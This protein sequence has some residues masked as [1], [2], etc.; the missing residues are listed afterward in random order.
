MRCIAASFISVY[1]LSNLREWTEVKSVCRSSL[2]AFIYRVCNNKN[3]LFI[4]VYSTFMWLQQNRLNLNMTKRLCVAQDW[5]SVSVFQDGIEGR[6][7]NSA[8]NNNRLALFKRSTQNCF[9]YQQGTS[10]VC[11]PVVDS[12]RSTTFYNLEALL[13]YI[14]KYSKKSCRQCG[15]L[16][17]F[18][19]SIS[20][21]K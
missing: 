1:Q 8:G 3:F 13:R 17:F 6:H 19:R 2:H 21:K 12:F 20:A 14:V 5:Y 10:Y 4:A 9:T 7:R 18:S 11:T 15:M 16:K